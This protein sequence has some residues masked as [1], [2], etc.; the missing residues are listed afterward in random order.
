MA[1]YRGVIADWDGAT[2]RAAI[3]L[4]GSPNQT[5]TDVRTSVAIASADMTAGRR[6]LVDT[7][8][9]NDPQDAVVTAVWD[10]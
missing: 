10:A 3:R 4:D 5:M 7:G 9:H 6:V 2:F 8:D 1:V